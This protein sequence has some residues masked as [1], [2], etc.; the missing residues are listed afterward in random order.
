[1]AP[2]S[3]AG[4]AYAPRAYRSPPSNYY[5]APQ[6]NYYGAPQPGYYGDP[7]SPAYAQPAPNVI[8]YTSAM[9][10][11]PANVVPPSN[12]LPADN[13]ATGAHDT[14]SPP[15]APRA[16]A[17]VQPPANARVSNSLVRLTPENVREMAKQLHGQQSALLDKL[18]QRVASA[19]QN[20]PDALAASDHGPQQAGRAQAQQALGRIRNS[21]KSGQMSGSDL[22]DL[23][24]GLQAAFPPAAQAAPLADAAQLAVDQQVANWVTGQE[25]T[26]DNNGDTVTIQYG[27]PLNAPAAPPGAAK[28]PAASNVAGGGGAGTIN[29]PG[30]P[31][32]RGSLG[33]SNTVG[34][35]AGAFNAGSIAALDNPNNTPAQEMAAW[36]ASGL[37]GQGFSDPGGGGVSSAANAAAGSG[38]GMSNGGMVTP[39]KL[40]AGTGV[41][42]PG[43]GRAGRNPLAGTGISNAA[44]GARR[45]GNTA[46]GGRRRGGRNRALGLIPGLPDGMMIPIGDDAM[47]I[48]MDQPGD[49]IILGEGDPAE[50]AGLAVA[51]PE[52]APAPASS[53]PPASGDV[54]LANAGTGPVGY[55][56]NQNPFTM[57]PND[58]QTLPA[59]SS[60]EIHFDRGGG[61]GSGDYQLSAGYYEFRPSARGWELYNKSFHATLDNRGGRSPFSYVVDN[62]PQT[63][64]PGQSRELSGIYPP[65][66]RFENGAGQF[67]QRR[68]EGSSYRV[69]LGADRSLDI[70]AADSVSSGRGVDQMAAASQTAGAIPPPPRAQPGA[71]AMTAA[72]SSTSQTPPGASLPPG[73]K[74]FDPVA[75][76][77]KPQTAA[78]LP[79]AFS[80]FRAAASRLGLYQQ[81]SWEGPAADGLAFVA[82]SS[83]IPP[84]QTSDMQQLQGTWVCSA[85]AKGGNAVRDFVGVRAVIQDD[86]LTW[87]FPQPDGTYRRQPAKYRIDP[88]QQPKRFDWWT[89][90][91]P[92]AVELRIYSL[93][94]GEL[95]WA[96]NLD[97]KT[98][99]ATFES[100]LWQF[101]MKRAAQES[102]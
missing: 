65:V 99:P 51:P 41:A 20:A 30:N 44:G 45:G 80:L 38:L 15:A 17:A 5:G 69:A 55:N 18:G 101:T 7:S 32:T 57:Q 2:S 52:A 71:A 62:Q 102:K 10:V 85:T 42:N 88:T 25:S 74:L 98:R 94:A 89:E 78:S 34:G 96:T 13:L 82:S 46:G 53:G 58:E 86:G 40:G 26:T 16:V 19:A 87:F 47:L 35:G 43:M 84:T 3:H 6:N 68:L 81:T 79:P 11:L 9:P 28:G 36:K 21:L 24:S 72:A 14:P 75:A 70:Y 29:P 97:R 76:L 67:K 49:Q 100:G 91:K 64:P 60:W 22:A 93:A 37:S 27:A 50:V 48:G 12:S 66:V 23:V 90:E 59:G 31:G 54:I 92:E 8:P 33:M 39:S 56:V 4:S 63:I 95:R 1:L 61:N 83:P 77:T 73:F